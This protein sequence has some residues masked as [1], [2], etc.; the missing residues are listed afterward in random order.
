[1]AV[2]FC[3]P[4]GTEPEVN[5]EL[6]K[7]WKIKTSLNHNVN[8]KK[9]Q[10]YRVW[11]IQVL[12]FIL[13]YEVAVISSPQIL[14]EIGWMKTIIRIRR[15]LRTW[16]HSSPTDSPSSGSPFAPGVEQDLHCVAFGCQDWWLEVMVIRRISWRVSAALV[17]QYLPIVPIRDLD[18]VLA[19]AVA[20]FANNFKVDELQPQYFI[21]WHS[22]AMETIL[23]ISRI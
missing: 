5:F 7:F 14:S 18:I 21:A 16:C 8:S 20:G 11:I 12:H 3:P 13:S 2:N 10:E 6:F 1:M 17:H 15:P 23:D 19:L 22:P 4:E 9:K